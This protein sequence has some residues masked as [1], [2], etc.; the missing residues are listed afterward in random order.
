MKK[1]EYFVDRRTPPT[2]YLRSQL[3]HSVGETGTYKYNTG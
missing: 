1:Y 2:A 3:Y